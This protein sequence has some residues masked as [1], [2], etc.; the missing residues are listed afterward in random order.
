MAD[1]KK[2]PEKDAIVFKGQRISFRELDALSNCLA[3]AL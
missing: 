2:T 3:N 1:K